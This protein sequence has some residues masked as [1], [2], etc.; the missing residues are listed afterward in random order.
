MESLP[1]RVCWLVGAQ[2]CAGSEGRPKLHGLFHCDANEN[3]GFPCEVKVDRPCSWRAYDA[4]EEQQ[5]LVHTLF[6]HLVSDRASWGNSERFFSVPG[7]RSRM[8][9]DRSG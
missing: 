8:S 7:G 6:P 9:A 2:T 1:H 5:R 3:G 4:G